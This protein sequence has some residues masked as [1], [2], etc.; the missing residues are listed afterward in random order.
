MEST[1]KRDFTWRGHRLSE[2]D[3]SPEQTWLEFEGRLTR[4]HLSHGD[5]H[6]TSDPEQ[7]STGP[8][9]AS[10]RRHGQAGMGE[11]AGPLLP[12]P[13]VHGGWE[14]GHA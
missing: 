2:G 8:P 4:A 11:M 5:G 6:S 1:D 9:G 3:A 14:A 12:W 7:A 13:D 10:S